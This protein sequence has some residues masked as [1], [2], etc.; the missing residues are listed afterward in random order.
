M[1]FCPDKPE[2]EIAKSTVNK[3]ACCILLLLLSSFL[4]LF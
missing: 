1:S 4:P 2:L 3:Y